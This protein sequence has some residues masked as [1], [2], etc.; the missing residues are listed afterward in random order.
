MAGPDL[1]RARRLVVKIG[2]ALLVDSRTGGIRRAWLASL[3]RDIA[4]ARARGT[5]VI[6]VSSGAIALGRRKLAL[7][8]GALRL[9]EKQAA[10][11]T[12]QPALMRAYD[13]ALARHDLAV[14]QVLLTLEETEARRRHLN[15][16]DTLETLLKLGV[17]PVINENDTVATEEIRFGDNDRLAA[18]VAA[19]LKADALVLLSDV[20]GL[21]TADPR[22]DPAARH[23]ALVE[24]VDAKTLAMAGPAPPGHSSGGMVTKLAAARIATGAGTWMAIAPGRARHPLSA[25][26]QGGAA[27]WFRPGEAPARARTRWI[28]GHL[29]TAGTLVVD[30]G[31]AAALRRGRSLLPAGV[32][33]VEGRFERGDAVLVR[34]KDGRELARGLVAYPAEEARRIAGK[35]SGEIAAL[36]GYH[37]REEIIHRDDLALL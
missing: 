7:K 6:V 24:S 1:L 10:A 2:S 36:L 13:A 21:Y 12:G 23:V 19:M 34:D 11:A 15:A 31:A 27:T 8:D 33:A 30:A 18:R 16:R 22:T 9:E 17:V 26:A 35:R 3:A 14:A 5:G 37:G 20:D 25:L 32:V 4:Q 29:R 28:A